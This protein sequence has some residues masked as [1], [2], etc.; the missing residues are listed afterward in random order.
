MS[1]KPVV[2]AAAVRHQTDN[3]DWLVYQSEGHNPHP[4]GR[5]PDVVGM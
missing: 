3:S 2:V 4:L 5:L 1:K